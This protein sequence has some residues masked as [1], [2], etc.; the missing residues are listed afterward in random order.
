MAKKHSKL[1]FNMTI[2]LRGLASSKLKLEAKSFFFGIMLERFI[3]SSIVALDEL[4]NLVFLGAQLLDQSNHSFGYFILCFKEE[5]PTKIG[6]IIDCKQPKLRIPKTLFFDGTCVNEKMLS[7]HLAPF[8][9]FFI[10]VFL[11]GLG[12]GAISA[13]L[14]LVLQFPVIE[15]CHSSDSILRNVAKLTVELIDVLGFL[16]HSRDVGEVSGRFFN[17]HCNATYKAVCSF[18]FMIELEHY[19]IFVYD[20]HLTFIQNSTTSCYSHCKA[21]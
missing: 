3:F 12:H 10:E 1:P 21:K 5:T 14:E 17:V 15:L 18:N 11:S 6:C 4:D 20:Y 9:G 2:L 8:L 7:G 16:L 19:I 13:T